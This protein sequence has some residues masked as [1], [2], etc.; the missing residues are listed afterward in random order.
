MCFKN[1]IKNFF[2]IALVAVLLVLYVNLLTWDSNQKKESNST[3][4]E[5]TDIPNSSIATSSSFEGTD[6]PNSSIATS[7]SFMTTS[8]STFAI[9]SLSQSLNEIKTNRYS[10]QVDKKFKIH[11]EYLLIHYWPMSNLSDVVG[12]A[13]FVRGERYYFEENRFGSVNSFMC[14]FNK[15]YLK[16]PEVIY[17]SFNFTVTFWF[18]YTKLL[19]PE[20]IFRFGNQE[21]GD[22]FGCFVRYYFEI[23]CFHKI[24]NNDNN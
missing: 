14:F 11:Y 3:S 24:D 4:F 5:G 6:I 13:N 18:Y 1:P 7:S 19:G 10:N 16:F 22:I 17:F 8:I 20:Q 15:G 12:G 9:T 2:L 23:E 21:K